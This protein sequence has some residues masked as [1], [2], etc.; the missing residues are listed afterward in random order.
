MSQ[1]QI[2]MEESLKNIAAQF[3]ARLGLPALIT[4]TRATLTEE[5]SEATIFISVFPEDKEKEMLDTL[6][7]YRSDM[8]AYVAEHVRQ[9]AQ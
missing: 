1:R 5:L 3:I 8:K 9:A 4:V 2:R 7:H 6:L